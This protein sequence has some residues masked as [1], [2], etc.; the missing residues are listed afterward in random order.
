MRQAGVTCEPRQF[1]LAMGT[2]WRLGRLDSP[3]LQEQPWIRPVDGKSRDFAEPESRRTYFYEPI[4][5]IL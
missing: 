5:P 4:A 3:A 2:L 1:E